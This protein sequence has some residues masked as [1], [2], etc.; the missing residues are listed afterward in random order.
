MKRGLAQITKETGTPIYLYDSL[1]I[2]SKCRELSKNLP[3]MNLYYACKAN[4]NPEIIKIIYKEGFGIETVSPGEI[5]IAKKADVPV[6]KII[7][8]C[9]NISEQE[10]TSVIKQGIKV[11]LDSLQ[12]VLVVGKNFPG[13][14]ISVRLNQ[15]IG[16][17]HH[18]HV[19]TGGPDSKFG[20]DISQIKD[21]KKIAQKYNL[22]ITGLHQHIGSNVLDALIL[23]KAMKKL[24]TTALLFPELKYL[25]FGGGFGIAY[26]KADKNLD[27]K[28]FGIEV[29]KIISDFSKKLGRKL[30]ISFEPGRYPVAEAGSLLVEVTDIKKNP[31]KKFIGVNSGFNH[32][33]RPAI[34][35]SYHEIEN[36]SNPK[37]KKEKVTIAGN[38]CES[39][40]VFA[41]NRLIAK[42]K[43]G[44]I[45]VI[46]NTGAYGYAM[47]SE[48]NSR[49]RPKE[50]LL[51]GNKIKQI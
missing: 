3:G 1:I 17:G 43:I 37:G 46:K 29:K 11:H 23:S 48:Y 22:K 10:L 34:Y 32:L 45:L 20:I 47:S 14:E 35:D 41:K 50:L 12:Q 49:P 6:S 38:V 44:D 9:S 8:T 13:T 19:I 36:V 16:A 5:R 21:L 18:S 4:T 2:Q 39:G 24:L 33:I 31:S 42:V 26:N 7:F 27:V 15:G 51:T 30:E 25:D 40:D 28:K